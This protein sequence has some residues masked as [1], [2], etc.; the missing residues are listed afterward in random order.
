MQ[1]AAAELLDDHDEE[2]SDAEDTSPLIL[3]NE[4]VV[5]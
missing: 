2:V 3:K 1:E 5:E 4:N